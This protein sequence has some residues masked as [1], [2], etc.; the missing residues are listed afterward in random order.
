MEVFQ[1]F[2][3][4][5]LQIRSPV[6][7]ISNSDLKIVVIFPEIAVFRLGE[8]SPSLIIFSH[9]TWSKLFWCRR[10]ILSLSVMPLISALR[11]LEQYRECA[12]AARKRIELMMRCC[13]STDY[14][15]RRSVRTHYEGPKKMDRF[16]QFAPALGI[17]V[18]SLKNIIV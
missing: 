7:L 9:T 2:F 16:L 8:R 4:K 13:P 5:T 18:G 14:E 3:K 12:Q 10:G 11:S 6:T 15:W 1:A 17:D